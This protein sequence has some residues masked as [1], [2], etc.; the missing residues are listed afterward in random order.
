MSVESGT[1]I[2]IMTG[3]P[4]PEGADSVVQ[5]ELTGEGRGS[6]RGNVVEVYAAVRV[7]A[8]LPQR[9]LEGSPCARRFAS[10][11]SG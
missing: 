5:F 7:N 9:L 1:A 6:P 3:A 2:R 4:L 8:R 11:W 10:A